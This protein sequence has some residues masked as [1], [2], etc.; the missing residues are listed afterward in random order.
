MEIN[1]HNLQKINP[2]INFRKITL[3]IVGNFLFQKVIFDFLKFW[4]INFNI[5]NL[6]K[7]SFCYFKLLFLFFITKKDF[8]KF[9]II[10]FNFKMPCQMPCGHNCAVNVR[11]IGILVTW[12]WLKW[13]QG[14]IYKIEFFAG[15]DF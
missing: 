11:H 5:F 12:L 13:A 7:I 1:F 2:K 14:H 10:F 4:K 3:K 9:K 6:I 15:T 8:Q